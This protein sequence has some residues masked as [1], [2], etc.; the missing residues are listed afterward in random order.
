MDLGRTIFAQ[1]TDFLPQREFRVWVER[2]SGNR[3]IK[4][5]TC[6]DQYLWALPVS[7]IS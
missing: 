2:Y 5:F 4:P 1:L 3:K 7:V 6:W